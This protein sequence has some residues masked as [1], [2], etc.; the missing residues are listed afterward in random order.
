MSI[1]INPKPPIA[2]VPVVRDRDASLALTDAEL[3]ALLA[4]LRER[5]RWNFYNGPLIVEFRTGRD[6]FTDPDFAAVAKE[7][8][9]DTTVTR[10]LKLAENSS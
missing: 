3:D 8:V 2:Y 4:P 6:T 9:V 7:L 5:L 10:V 1:S